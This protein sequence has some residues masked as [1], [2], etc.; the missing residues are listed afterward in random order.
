[1][2]MGWFRSGDK[3]RLLSF[4]RFFPVFSVLILC[5][6]ECI[7]WLNKLFASK[8]DVVELAVHHVK[9]GNHNDLYVLPFLKRRKVV[10]MHC[11]VG[12]G[13]GLGLGRC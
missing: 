9:D 10:L 12:S 2:K 5:V 6:W 11:C 3:V 4:S 1:M 8:A 13:G 7:E